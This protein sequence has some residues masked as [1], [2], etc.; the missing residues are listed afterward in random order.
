LLNQFSLGLDVID[1]N[2]PGFGD[3]ML[4]NDTDG[5]NNSLLKSKLNLN[6][7]KDKKKPFFKKVNI[8]LLQRNSFSYE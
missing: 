5:D 2:I 1:Q 7:S 3:D 4:G 8:A 6:A